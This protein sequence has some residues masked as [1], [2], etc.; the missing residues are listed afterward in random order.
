MNRSQRM[1]AGAALALGL[2]A[3]GGAWAAAAD[4]AAKERN[5]ARTEARAQT[6]AQ[7]EERIYGWQLMTPEE[8]QALRSRMRSATPEERAQIRRE[9]HA[10]MQARARERGLELPDPP[11]GWAQGP[12]ARRHTMKPDAGAGPEQ[13]MRR[14][15]DDDRPQGRRGP[16]R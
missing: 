11:P 6:E 4:E 14:G 2:L 13:R 10:A 1:A 5:P 8:R 3:T 15:A 12:G 9:H 16:G 7:A